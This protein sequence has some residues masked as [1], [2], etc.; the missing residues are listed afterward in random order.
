MQ[1]T[2]EELA[3]LIQ[4]GQTEFIP[5]LWE[6][7]Q[8][9]L[10]YLA[11]RHLQNYPAH[12]QQLH[13]DMVHQVYLHFRKAIEHYQPGKGKFTSY[14]SYYAK[15]AF[16]EVLQGRTSRTKNEPLDSALSL[17]TP[18]EEITLADML[19][20]TQSE[21]YYRHLEDADLWQSV[22]ELLQQ[23]IERIP[24]EYQA[25]FLVMLE[26]G[27]GVTDTL[28][29]MGGNL[30]EKGRYYEQYRRGLKTIRSYIQGYLGR[31][32]GANIALEEC[33]SYYSGV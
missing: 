24:E 12:C 16:Q 14:L 31:E 32:K 8:D 11:D 21:E 33:I 4:S 5:Q 1:H 29:L 3:L 30:E 6:Q 26:H 2:N 9:F 19:I 22:H 7:V 28:R 17:D 13:G 10:A 25:F 18:I 15:N 23:A 27:T 20:D